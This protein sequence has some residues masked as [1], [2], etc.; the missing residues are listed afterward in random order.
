M[1]I[2]TRFV[3]TKYYCGRRV[4]KHWVLG[5][6][7]TKNNDYRMIIVVNEK[8]RTL[9]IKKHIVK[10]KEIHTDYFKSCARLV[11]GGYIHRTVN[12]SAEFV[13]K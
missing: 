2:E 8:A 5:M 1:I 6:V 10:S 3:K 4:E 13:G 11:T 9:I 7:D 12:H